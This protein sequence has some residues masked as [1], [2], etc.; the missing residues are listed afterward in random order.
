MTQL[1]ASYTLRKTLCALC[2]KKQGK[3]NRCIFIETQRKTNGVL[4]QRMFIYRNQQPV[5]ALDLVVVMTDR[6]YANLLR[7][8]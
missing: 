7:Q 3:K 6:Y 8:L 4:I 1:S 5:P 2:F